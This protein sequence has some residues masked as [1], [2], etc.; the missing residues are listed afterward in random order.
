M[1][2][3]VWMSRHFPQAIHLTRLPVIGALLVRSWDLLLR[4]ALKSC[5]VKPLSQDAIDGF[6]APYDSFES[7]IALQRFPQ[8]IP[9]RPSHPSYNDFLFIKEHISLLREKPILIC[10]GEK[11]FCFPGHFL[12]RWRH[13]FPNAIVKIYPEAAH[14]LLEEEVDVIPQIVDFLKEQD[15]EHTEKPSFPQP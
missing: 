14:L 10:W 15:V 6:K 8:D 4:K 9:T 11:D 1:N 2:S 13:F 7:R 5:T 3:V 12:K